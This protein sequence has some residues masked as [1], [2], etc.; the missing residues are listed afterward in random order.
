MALVV[1]LVS[2]SGS[3]AGEDVEVRKGELF[4]DTDPIVRKWPEH[5]GP[6]KV[7][8]TE[9][10]IEQATAAPGEKRGDFGTRMAAARAA[11][12]GA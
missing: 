3:M 9:A 6:P 12:R 2:L 5:F 11:K 7:R 8:G 10:P 1:A 4:Y